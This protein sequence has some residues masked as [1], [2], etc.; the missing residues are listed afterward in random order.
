MG[1]GGVRNAFESL[2]S[3]EAMV[4]VGDVLVAKETLGG[5]VTPEKGQ[6]KGGRILVAWLQDIFNV[7]IV[8]AGPQIIHTKVVNKT[9]QKGFDCSFVYGLNDIDVRT[10]TLFEEQV[11]SGLKP[12]K[13]FDMWGNNPAFDELVRDAG[14]FTVYGKKMFQVVKK[15]KQVKDAL[16]GLNKSEYSEVGTRFLS[17]KDELVDIQKQIMIN[18]ND[19]SYS[20][21]EKESE[22]QATALSAPFT[23]EEIRKA[24]FGILGIKA[25]GP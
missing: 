10:I 1:G 8:F 2:G 7:D 23:K 25:L 24:M 13:F 15:L 3:D 14:S 12:F 5:D 18:Y 20:L 9:L 19:H 17:V 6:D 4:M 22:E 21:Q 11:R 16:K